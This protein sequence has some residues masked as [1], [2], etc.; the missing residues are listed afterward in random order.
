MAL[1]TFAAIVVGFV[2]GAVSATGISTV[3]TRIGLGADR[4]RRVSIEEELE[5]AG[6]PT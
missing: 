5:N 6:I 3:V 4:A 1:K 2:L